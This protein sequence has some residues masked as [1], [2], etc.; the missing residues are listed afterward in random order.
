MAKLVQD[1][2][3]HLVCWVCGENFKDIND[4]HYACKSSAECQTETLEDVWIYSK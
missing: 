1:D 2:V 3:P 4:S